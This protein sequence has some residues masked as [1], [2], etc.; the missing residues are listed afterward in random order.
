MSSPPPDSDSRRLAKNA[1]W[2]V[3]GFAVPA[4]VTL[5]AIPV[6][7]YYLGVR[8]YGMFAL[9]NSVLGLAMILNFGLGQATTK[10]VAEYAE[11]GQ[12]GA[13]RSMVY[14]T[15]VFYMVVGVA[16][17]IGLQ[18]A[19]AP[20]AERVLDLEGAEAAR[21]ARVLEIVAAGFVPYVAF[22]VAQGLFNGLQQYRA[23]QLLA[24]GRSVGS[25]IAG[26]VMLALGTG[27]EGL[28]AAIVAVSW[29]TCA[30]GFAVGI[31]RLPPSDPALRAGG[32]LL[33]RIAGFSFY[34]SV[35]SIGSLMAAQLDKILLGSLLGLEAVSIYSVAQSAAS[36]INVLNAAM[37]R[38]LMPFFSAREVDP[39]RAARMLQTFVT[40]WRASLL[41][42]VSLAT[43]AIAVAP[44]ALEL[45]LD[46]SVAF[47]TLP[48]FVIFAVVF[49]LNAVSVVPYFYLLGRGHPEAIAWPVL[50][51]GA[52][53][54]GLVALLAPIAGVAG[55][56][57]ASLSYPIISMSM[58]L[59]AIRM[60]PGY[61]RETGI[62]QG[63]L[64]FAGAQLA[65][66][67]AGF[68]A[69][70]GLDAATGSPAIALLGAAGSFV[71]VVGLATIWAG[72]RDHPIF[73]VFFTIAGR[74][75][76]SAAASAGGRPGG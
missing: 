57:L 69:G 18:L 36:K 70:A 21:A 56:A 64:G 52:A 43:L 5:V 40:A 47:A 22:T 46:D 32:A 38:V 73:S 67:L 3:I 25:L 54:L 58:C 72:R 2:S 48:A 28:T 75:G 31:R 19:S 1:A 23:S 51:G 17:W 68:A 26:V 59:A 6:Y 27:I 37:S 55:A 24:I 42:G 45:W 13:L 20:L 71:L 65:A 62:R 11:R 16:G 8:D 50:L 33:R 39:E 63:T 44:W 15:L 12:G 29:L 14:A 7:I 35:T 74:L 9:A 60:T 4:A 66:G 53:M 76:A 34:T 49:G 30:L 10:F 61:S 41:A